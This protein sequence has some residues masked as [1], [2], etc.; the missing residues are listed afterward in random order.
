MIFTNK[1]CII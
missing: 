1:C